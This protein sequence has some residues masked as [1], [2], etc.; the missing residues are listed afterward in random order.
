MEIVFNAIG[1][2]VPNKTAFNNIAENAEKRG[3]ASLSTNSDGV[4]HGRCWRIGLGLEVWTI[5]SESKTGEI[6][7]ADCR[8]GFR[9]RYTQVLNN[10]SMSE[11]KG[12]AAV[13]GFTEM[14]NVKV[15][16]K[17]QN[18]TEI[19]H[20]KFEQKHLKVGLCGLAY[21]AEVLATEEKS[22]WKPSSTENSEANRADWNL[23]GKILAF[24][25]LRNPFT[26]KDLYW[27]HLVIN[28]FRL[29]ILV[30]KQALRGY[31]LQ[32]GASLKAKIWLQ[33]HVVSQSTFYS[34]YEGV[35]WSQNTVDFWKTFKRE[36]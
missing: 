20:T 2:E 14:H 3:E 28:N 17:L 24:N 30:N 23:C 15:H 25:E 16:F 32:V 27:I 35:D 11:A 21:K 1:I 5:L 36:N 6:F 29:E 26:E 9:A 10:W 33:G 19:S 18:L 8:P 4:I 7:Y 22:F 31:A 13:E 34:S 12:E